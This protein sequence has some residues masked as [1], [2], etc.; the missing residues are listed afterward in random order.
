[1]IADRI[2]GYVLGVLLFLVNV[3]VF[4]N[5]ADIFYKIAV[6]VNKLNGD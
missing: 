6:V 3:L 5:L 2:D 1:M 4:F